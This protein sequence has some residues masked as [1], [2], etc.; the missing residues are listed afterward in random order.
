MFTQTNYK[1]IK[2]Y[3]PDLKP[4]KHLCERVASTRIVFRVFD[5]DSYRGYDPA[6]G[7]EASGF[8][9]RTRLDDRLAE[10]HLSWGNCTVVTPWL[11]T[12]RRWLWAVW[13]MNRRFGGSYS[14][15]P[16]RKRPSSGIRVAVIDL[17]ACRGNAKPPVHALSVLSP[18][19]GL[20]K[21]A[22]MSDE[23]LIYGRVPPA[24]II[25]IWTYEKAIGIAGLPSSI[26]LHLPTGSYL[27]YR[28]VHARIVES[29]D[30]PAEAQS[31]V[32]REGGEKCANIG[33]N[34]LQDGYRRLEEQLGRIVGPV[35]EAQAWVI[36]VTPRS[37]D[38]LDNLSQEMGALS[39][40][41][42]RGITSNLGI[43][44][45]RTPNP[46]CA[47]T[48]Q[49]AFT[50]MN[51]GAYV[52]Q[53]AITQARQDLTRAI[54]TDN[55][56]TSSILDAY[57]ALV[58]HHKS[59]QDRLSRST[60][61]H[62]SPFDHAFDQLLRLELSCFQAQQ[63]CYEALIVRLAREQIERLRS[64][65][66]EL[67]RTVPLGLVDRLNVDQLDWTSMKCT[68]MG[69]VDAWLAPLEKKLDGLEDKVV[70]GLVLQAE[71]G[72]LGNEQQ[73]PK[74]W[75]SWGAQLAIENAEQTRGE[76]YYTYLANEACNLK[77]GTKFVNW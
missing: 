71:I 55:T 61:S 30:K 45:G 25:S 73:Y 29:L 19:S 50:Q 22:N 21:F 9:E 49:D 34:M 3:L 77:L 20:R 43:N 7:F 39:T 58:A 56:S 35:K 4:A 15:S 63:Q 75:E 70:P 46:A 14:S 65:A 44:G 42:D 8:D 66:L 60:S 41:S 74:W 28:D 32:A 13:E 26:L 17:D 51:K 47:H 33:I 68:M 6:T 11:S 53:K 64:I 37:D 76:R 69:H 31:W 62:T 2:D 12:T 52:F 40:D 10:A 24:A 27:S 72:W 36:K 5:S 38:L 16:A 57:T 48:V 67:A 54:Q 1:N 23:I 59:V 18:T